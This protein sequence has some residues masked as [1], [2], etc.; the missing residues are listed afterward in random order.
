TD[1]AV[2]DVASRAV[3]NLTNEKDPTRSW[4]VVAWSGDGKTIYANRSNADGTI[5]EIYSIDVA[6]GRAENLTP[7]S[8]AAIS[9]YDLSP[10]GRT[11][12]VS[13][14]EKGG[15]DNVATLDIAS[16]TLTWITDLKWEA[17]ADGFSPDGKW[18]TYSVNEDG[19]LDAYIAP[20]AGGAPRQL[21]IPSGVNFLTGRPSPFSPDGKRLLDMHQSST[22]LPDLWV[23]DLATNRAHQLTHS[24]VA[25]LDATP[26]P[27]SQ[28][29][30]YRSFDGTTISAFL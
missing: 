19:R 29:V 17:G 25:S 28:L 6:T 9:G 26:L 20:V 23:Y 15:F 27:A 13:S 3:R 1:I 5:G 2:L 12:L 21:A 4:S 16:K 10:D 11:L 7:N 18:L 30:H 22:D 14:N 24:S 8:R